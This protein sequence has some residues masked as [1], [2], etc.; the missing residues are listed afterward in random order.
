MTTEQRNSKAWEELTNR[1][2]NRLLAQFPGMKPTDPRYSILKNVVLEAMDAA[3]MYE[4][5]LLMDSMV[6]FT[7]DYLEPMRNDIDA[8]LKKLEL[9]K[10]PTQPAAEEETEMKSAEGAG[11]LS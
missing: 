1:Y 4:V 10:K 7:G 3:T 2:Y 6:K 8:I 5:R 9:Q 11:P